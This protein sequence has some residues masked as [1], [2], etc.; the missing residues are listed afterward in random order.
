MAQL[1]TNFCTRAWRIHDNKGIQLDYKGSTINDLGG[2]ENQEKKNSKAL[3]EKKNF[4]RPSWKKKF[5]KGLAEEKKFLKWPSWGKKILKRLPWGKKIR[6]RYFLR[7]PDHWWSS[8]KGP[9]PP[10]TGYCILP[11][12]R[13][14]WHI[15][16]WI[17]DIMHW[18]GD[19]EITEY[20]IWILGY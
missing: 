20:L 13:G 7:P 14:Y 1:S 15:E 4:K 10:K 18:K 9:A 3:Q 8:P 6:V 12:N 5:S 11:K 19:I 2:G 16:I 17:L